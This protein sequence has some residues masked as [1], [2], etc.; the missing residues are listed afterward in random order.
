MSILIPLERTQLL[1][2]IQQ[3]VVASWQSVRH[4]LLVGYTESLMFVLIVVGSSSVKY[5]GTAIPAYIN[6][7]RNFSPRPKF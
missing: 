6:L 7:K 4:L 2:P 3:V 1:S 5:V